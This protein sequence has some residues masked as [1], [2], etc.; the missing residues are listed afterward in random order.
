MTLTL[1][2]NCDKHLWSCYVIWTSNS[3]FGKNE[4]EDH[5]R[6]CFAL[7]FVYV[8][9]KKSKAPKLSPMADDAITQGGIES[10]VSLVSICEQA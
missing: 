8:V 1:G 7:A 9:G 2:G 5:E 6:I 3:I 10:L 4:R